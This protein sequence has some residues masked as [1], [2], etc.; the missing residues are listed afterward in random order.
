MLRLHEKVFG[1]RSLSLRLREEVFMPAFE[2]PKWVQLDLMER[3]FL[4]KLCHTMFEKVEL[5]GKDGS[6]GCGS[7]RAIA[8]VEFMQ[9]KS[10]QVAFLDSLWPLAFSRTSSCPISP[11]LWPTTCPRGVPALRNPRA[12]CRRG[13]GRGCVAECGPGWAPR[14][15][16]RPGAG[17]ASQCFG[18]NGPTA[19]WR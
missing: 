13:S 19:A 6:T 3:G 7:C 8:Q 17:C 1:V 18:R 16:S 10:M 14:R 2:A 4:K 9:H 15:R 11:P 12:P 5:P